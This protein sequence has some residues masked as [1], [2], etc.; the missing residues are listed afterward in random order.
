M[1][2]ILTQDVAHLG[3]IGEVVKVKNGYILSKYDFH[4][5]LLT[6]PEDISPKNRAR[7]IALDKSRCSLA[8]TP[9][10]RRGTI[11]PRS[12]K[13]RWIKGRFL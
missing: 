12:F 13:N 2:V 1:E 4:D 8:V 5:Y 6:P 3:K 10:I 7:L 11:F 9:E